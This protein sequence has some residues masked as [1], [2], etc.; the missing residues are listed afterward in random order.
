MKRVWGSVNIDQ[1]PVKVTVSTAIY[2]GGEQETVEL[3]TSGRYYIKN[4]SSYLQYEEDGD[5]QTTVKIS[6][7]EVLILRRGATKMRLHFL[8]NKKTAGNFQTP[9][10]ILETSALTKRLDTSFNEVTREGHVDLLYD[11]VIQGSSGGTYHM[12][13]SYKEEG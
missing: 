13:I 8:L 11:L 5:I 10:G 6:G 12:T 7:N 4:K 9:Y 2:S 3:T 1:I